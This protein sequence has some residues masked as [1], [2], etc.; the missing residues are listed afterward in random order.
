MLLVKTTWLRLHG[1]IAAELEQSVRSLCKAINQSM[2]LNVAA[3]LERL[4]RE[5]AAAVA[6][7]DTGPKPEPVAR[8]VG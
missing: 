6:A 1:E 8:K 5:D 4:L 7:D 3:E 2:P